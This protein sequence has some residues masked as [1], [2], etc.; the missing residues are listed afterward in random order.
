MKN[1][2]VLVILLLMI[3]IPG[4]VDRSLTNEENYTALDRN[5]VVTG[6]FTDRHKVR[7]V[8]AFFLKNFFSISEEL[9]NKLPYYNNILLHSL[10]IFFSLLILKKTFK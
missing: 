2:I 8:K 3:I 9:N 10:L 1:I 6:D 4:C 7:W 5:C